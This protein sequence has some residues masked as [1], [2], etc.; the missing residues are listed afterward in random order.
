[1]DPQLRQ[2]PAFRRHQQ[3]HRRR[4]RRVGLP[5]LDDQRHVDRYGIGPTYNDVRGLTDSGR[6]NRIIRFDLWERS[7]DN[8]GDPI[9]YEIKETTSG[10]KIWQEYE[11][12]LNAVLS[13]LQPYWEIR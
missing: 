4:E 3:D 9:P 13:N 8:N 10:I 6:L 11:I 5:R 1:M 12:N 2:R 7:L